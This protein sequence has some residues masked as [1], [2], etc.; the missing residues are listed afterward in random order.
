MKIVDFSKCN[1]CKHKDLAD[2]ED[3]CYECLS[4]PARENSR[5]P[6]KYEKN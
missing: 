3:P 5:T 4:E 2:T 6:I 1:T